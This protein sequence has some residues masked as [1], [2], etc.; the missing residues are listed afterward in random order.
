MNEHCSV[1]TCRSKDCTNL[2]DKPYPGKHCGNPIKICKPLGKPPGEVKREDC[3]NH[4][5]QVRWGIAECRKRKCEDLK[6]DPQWP[7][8][9]ERCRAGIFNLMPGTLPCCIKDPAMDPVTF[10]KHAGWHLR[11]EADREYVYKNPG[12]KNC[13]AACP[14]KILTDGEKFV[15]EKGAIKGKKVPAKIWRCAFHG[16]IL[17]QGHSCLCHVL[18]N[19]DQEHQIEILKQIVEVRSSKTFDELKDS[20]PMDFCPDGVKRYGIGETTCPVIKLPLADLPACPLW[21]IPAKMLPAPA[22]LP[23]QEPACPP[24][25]ATAIPTKSRQVNAAPSENP[26]KKKRTGR[27]KAEPEDP[28]CTV[29]RERNKDPVPEHACTWCKEEQQQRGRRAWVSKLNLEVLHLGDMQELGEQ[30]PDGSVDLIFTD[31]PYVKDQWEDAYGHLGKLAARVLKP[32]GFLFTY[33]PQAHLPDIM[34]SLEYSGTCSENL[35]FFW[36]I[37]SLNKGPHQKAYKWNAICKH[38]PILIYQKVPNGE[39][40]RGSRRCFS[41]V[42]NGY[43]QKAHHP[44][45]QSVHD[46]LGIISRFCSDGEILLD[47]FA[48]TGTTLKAAKLL[49]L[50]WIGFEIDPKTHAIAI[51]ELGQ[52]PV[53][54]FTFGEEE[55]DPVQPRE[56]VEGPKD[57][58]KQA[59]IGDPAKEARPVEL[60]SACL[61]CEGRDDCRTHDPKGGC[62]NAVKAIQEAA[63]ERDESP[64]WPIRGSCNNCQ[65]S[66][67]NVIMDSCPRLENGVLADDLYGETETKPCEFWGEREG[68]NGKW[69]I[70]KKPA[71]ARSDGPYQKDE[72]PVKRHKS[73]WGGKSRAKQM[74][75]EAGKEQDLPGQCTSCG[76]HKTLRTFYPSCP[77]LPDLLFKG[78]ALSADQLMAETLADGCE[79][80]IRIPCSTYCSTVRDCKSLSWEDGV[81]TTTGKKVADMTYCPTQHL[82]PK[83]L[84]K[85]KQLPKLR[86]P[87]EA[88]V[89]NGPA[90]KSR[91]EPVITDPI[92]KFL[93]EHLEQIVSGKDVPIVPGIGALYDETQKRAKRPLKL[94][95]EL[96]GKNPIRYWQ[97]SPSGKIRELKGKPVQRR[98]LFAW[99]H[100]WKFGI[101]WFEVG[102]KVAKK[103]ERETS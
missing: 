53:M 69:L 27:K 96:D 29:C 21:R 67:V 65:H 81:C 14:Y 26:D 74:E 38:K 75:E 40:I 34:D 32:H 62:L 43:R 1:Q 93:N 20:C 76:H 71:L 89:G 58:S 19:P 31:P 95:L 7:D 30:V 28:I 50:Q 102:N 36:I 90:K 78:G 5:Y 45:Q 85:K 57:T 23:V 61:E 2:G 97:V 4:A 52:K 92:A 11:E 88:K 82:V 48:G 47:P 86:K 73:N 77:R 42:V 80:W 39:D 6:K 46:V 79:H 33:A 100:G 55:P 64:P 99:N 41:D 15:F 56:V 49:G 44:W 51:R 94:V 70:G 25:A 37:Q 59:L 72:P 91:K 68:P 12:P 22:S 66:A 60:H 9:Q 13:P 103:K 54:L 63:R 35:T 3:P 98:A 24:S 83:A 84:P 17:G 18:G 16:D 10:L 87:E 8:S 101:L